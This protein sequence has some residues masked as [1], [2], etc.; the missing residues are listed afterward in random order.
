MILL[1][2]EGWKI[3]RLSVGHLLGQYSIH[4]NCRPNN[5][6]GAWYTLMKLSKNFYCTLCQCKVPDEV[7]FVLEMTK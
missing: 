4:H 5:E 7:V 3:N 2:Y 6:W 1:E